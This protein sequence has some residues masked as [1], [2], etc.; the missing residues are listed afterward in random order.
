M[1]EIGHT[2]NLAH[3]WQ[4]SLGTAWV[5]TPDEPSALSYMN[6]PYNYPAGLD[7]FFAAFEYGFSPSELLFMRHAPERFVKMGAAPWFSQH[8]FEEEAYEQVRAAATGPLELEVRVHRQT[9]YEFLEP[10]VVELRLRNVSTTP[11][12]VD[13]AVLH[14]DGL[15]L[16]V[17][18][19]GGEAK[20]WLP[21]S[22]QCT[23]PV[24]TVLAPGEAIYESVFVSAGTGGWLISDPGRYSV[25]AALDAASGVTAVSRPLTLVVDQPR[26]PEAE[27]LAGEV[28][29][30]GVA[31]TL[32]FGGTRVL[33]EAN[34]TLAEVAER[35]PESRVAVHAT[36]VLGAPMASDG[37]VLRTD[38]DGHE[39]FDVAPAAPEEA[40][41]LLS[42]AL[43]DFDRAADSLGHIE[44]TQQTMRL[45]AVLDETGDSDA[46]ADLL[47]TSADALERRGVLPGVVA[48]LRRS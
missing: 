15:A 33:H 39:V 9:P 28:F 4:K 43:S 34:N 48:A 41:E 35:M 16:V 6:Y 29:S 7:A 5:P 19:E 22:R 1:H 36:A 40:R 12:V 32:A 8:G 42:R 37:K 13:S 3:S 18:R 24:P 31:H 11:Q 21:F 27:R 47:D 26:D 2:F 45:A 23:A 17:A 46:K 38:A 20:R 30:Q 10:V 44:V 25:Y 14:G